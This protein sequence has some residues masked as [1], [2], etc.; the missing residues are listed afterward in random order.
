MISSGNKNKENYFIQKSETLNP[1]E[2]QAKIQQFIEAFNYFEVY[3]SQGEKVKTLP[4]TDWQIL[5]VP[6]TATLADV[7]KAFKKIAIEN[8]KVSNSDTIFFSF[9]FFKKKVTNPLLSTL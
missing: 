9:F 8:H 1:K 2:K 4:K 5:G 6:E 3:Y 7:K